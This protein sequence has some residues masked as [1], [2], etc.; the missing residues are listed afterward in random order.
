[1]GGGR[2]RGQ[3]LVFYALLIP[4]LFIFVGVALDLGWYYFNV[5]RLQN[6]ADAAAL[7]GAQDLVARNDTIFKGYNITL[8]ENKFSGYP[9]P[10]ED[11]ST[12][13]S[14]VVA[15]DYV[16]KNLS[17]D[18]AATTL[19]D[20]LGNA[21][22]YTMIDNWS[23]NASEVTMTPHLRQDGDVFYYVVHLTENIRHFLMPGR[24]EPIPAPVVAVAMLTKNGDTPTSNDPVL[25]PEEKK[26]LEDILNSNVIIGNWEIQNKYREQKKGAQAYE[27]NADGTDKLDENGKKI[28]LY[29]K[30]DA[31]EY[32]LDEN[33]NKIPVYTYTYSNWQAYIDRFGHAQYAER[34]NHFQDLCNHYYLEDKGNHIRRETV[35]IQDDLTG[36]G[37]FMRYGE[38][39]SVTATKAAINDDRA[40]NAYNPGVTKPKTYNPYYYG[41]T[42]AVSQN[43]TEKVGLPYTWDR[44]DSINIDFVPDVMFKEGSEYLSKNWDLTLPDAYKTASAYN[45]YPVNPP[46]VEVGDRK[47]LRVH[48]SIRFETPYKVRPDKGQDVLWG[49]IESEPMRYIP[50]ALKGLTG[51]VTPVRAL[52]SVR[53]IIINFNQ[54]NCGSE[55]R[56]IILFYEG[57]EKYD[58]ENESLRESK[59]VI[60]N[61]NTPF[62][63]ILYMPN[64]PVVVC[65]DKKAEFKGFIVAKK[66]VQLRE[67]KEFTFAKKRYYKKFP[68]NPLK[69]RLVNGERFKFEDSKGIYFTAKEDGTGEKFYVPESDYDIEEVYHL[70]DGNDETDYYKLVEDGITMFTD[71]YGNVAYKDLSEQ[72]TKCGE[73]DTFGR[74]DFT[75]HNYHIPKESANNLLRSE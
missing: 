1:M 48:N 26:K 70:K 23:P 5:S 71:K 33:G 61:F 57:P 8:V 44:L 13:E 15:A 45:H 19:K 46:E 49:R 50:D 28:K 31:G 6:A 52:N 54:S 66:Y 32:I 35:I 60:V 75:T 34:W 47:Y 42:P 58:G 36:S 65:G 11:I 12:D 53:Q 25:P 59:P 56:P 24:Y 3:V 30:D 55:D 29:L 10:D 22:A 17:S 51:N 2:N 74:T 62:R 40:G 67:E 43:K 64:S 37:E 27:K 20:D 38:N 69:Y 63:A 18:A 14:D 4:L 41:T 21:Y 68:N 16:R 9:D 73:Y 39:S 72:P 7:A